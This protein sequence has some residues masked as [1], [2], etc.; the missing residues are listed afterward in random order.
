M[1]PLNIDGREIYLRDLKI[2]DL[3]HLLKWYNNINDFSFATGIYEPIT[4]REMLSR[5]LISRASSKEFFAG[6]YIRASGEMIGVLKGQLKSDGNSSAWINSI[7]IDPG[8]QRKGYGRK[9][10]NLLI[11]HMKK[12]SKADSVYL[13]VAEENIKGMLFWKQQSF[14]TVKKIKRDYSSKNKCENIVIMCRE[15]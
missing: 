10:V 11:E 4:L 13:S 8:F 12:C 3:P 7:L 9:T 6:I 2:D 5:Y 15:I 14:R 1:Y